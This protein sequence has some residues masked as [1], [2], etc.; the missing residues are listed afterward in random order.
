MKRVES[1]SSDWLAFIIKIIKAFET[2]LQMFEA[3]RPRLVAGDGN[4]LRNNVSGSVTR[5]GN[6]LLL[7]AK[8]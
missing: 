4:S 8:F 7:W 6:N 5:L 2:F 1:Q 3:A